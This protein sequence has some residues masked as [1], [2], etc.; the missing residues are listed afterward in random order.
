MARIAQ[1]CA[2]AIGARVGLAGSIYTQIIRFFPFFSFLS[3]SSFSYALLFSLVSRTSSSKDELRLKI[4]RRR[5][6]TQMPARWLTV[7]RGGR[8][9]AI[10]S[11]SPFIYLFF[12]IL[13][14]FFFWFLFIWFW[15]LKV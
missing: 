6:T 10:T 14:S 11:L 4:N 12:R 3:L 1:V 13:S 8:T 2:A 9:A 7:V 15:D 5:R